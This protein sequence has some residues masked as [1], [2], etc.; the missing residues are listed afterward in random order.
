MK[1]RLFLSI[2]ILLFSCALLSPSESDS[3]ENKGTDTPK[4]HP[5]TTFSSITK[6][7]STVETEQINT[8][9]R[10]T[11]K[12][13][14]EIPRNPITVSNIFDSLDAGMY[15]AYQLGQS[16][17]LMDT[18]GEEMGLW[19]EIQ[20]GEAHSLSPNGE[21]MV[22]FR[23]GMGLESELDVYNFVTEEYY[24]LEI[25]ECSIGILSDSIWSS[26][27]RNIAISGCYG[28]IGIID[29]RT[30]EK[31]TT[32][33]SPVVFSEDRGDHT[34]DP[35]YPGLPF[36]SPNGLW[37]VYFV[38]YVDSWDGPGGAIMEYPHG[39]FITNTACFSEGLSCKEMTVNLNI[40]E[41]Q[42]LLSIHDSVLAWTP[43]SRLAVLPVSDGPVIYM[44]DVVTQRIVESI[45]LPYEMG[46]SVQ[47]MKYSPDGKWIFLATSPMA[48]FLY[49]M[50]TKETKLIGYMEIRSYFWVEKK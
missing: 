2:S 22:V 35:N 14:T 18:E 37:I 4:D 16:V 43:E 48:E 50:E 39:P 31:I 32:I 19:M 30:G 25:P 3:R 34:Y 36:W 11:T 20:D 26:D 33:E 46:M 40:K 9:A 45:V 29:I 12:T 23:Y 42:N 24:T 44:Y 6:T 10:P 7:P 47:S 5:N 17:Y 15:I 13:K 28:G 21:M 41:K 8:T 49:S 1:Y 27:G 38:Y